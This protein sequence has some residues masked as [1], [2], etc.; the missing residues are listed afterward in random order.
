MAV[1]DILKVEVEGADGE[2]NLTQREKE[3]KDKKEKAKAESHFAG[4]HEAKKHQKHADSGPEQAANAG[5]LHVFD[6]GDAV[7]QALNLCHENRFA[8]LFEKVM[9]ASNSIGEGEIA[10][11]V[12]EHHEGKGREKE[13]GSRQGEFHRMCIVQARQQED[14]SSSRFGLAGGQGAGG[15]GREQGGSREEAMIFVAINNY[16]SS[17]AQMGK[18]HLLSE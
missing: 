6:E 2:E 9:K 4:F 16:W 15:R 17:C 3:R 13:G 7:A 8:G 18:G 14:K 12:G 1:G 5:R 10:V 11:G